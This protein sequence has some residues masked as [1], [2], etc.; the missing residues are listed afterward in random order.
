MMNLMKISFLGA[1]AEAIYAF[2][3]LQATCAE[4]QV[5]HSGLSRGSTFDRHMFFNAHQVCQRFYCING[6]STVWYLNEESQQT[7]TKL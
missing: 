1:L 5:R 2:K 6:F 4:I 3:P 7:P